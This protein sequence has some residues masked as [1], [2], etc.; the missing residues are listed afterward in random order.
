[1][2]ALVGAVAVCAVGGLAGLT[3]RNPVLGDPSPGLNLLERAYFTTYLNLKSDV[4]TAPAGANPDPRPFSIAQGESVASLAERLEAEGLIAD[5]EVLVAYL[6]Y[7]GWDQSIEAGDFILRQ[8]MNLTEVARALT[9]A[10]AREVAV[11]IFEGWRR[12]QIAESLAAHPSLAVDVD[13]FLALTGPGAIAPGNY[14]FLADRPSSATLEGYLFPD[15]YLMRPGAT[16]QDMVRRLLDNFALQLSSQDEAAFDARGLSMYEAVTIASLIEREAVKDEERPIIASVIFNR[17]DS[18]QA[19]EIDA[20]VQ[21]G[22]GLP[23]DWWPQLTGLDL[24]SQPGPYNTYTI[25]G[26]PAGPISNVRQASL[27]AVAYP[28][29]TPYLYYQARCDGSGFHN[30]ATTYE[31]HVA[32]L[33]Q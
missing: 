31:E 27:T 21:F 13:E 26:L 25:V 19:L 24:R 7:T 14:D 10:S 18:G 33:C 20:T 1:V 32:N 28:A 3:A 4:L 11:R 5:T 17:L 8:T 22:M 15:T 16:A 12:E 9:D 29:Q 2:V 6:R 30:F 23:T